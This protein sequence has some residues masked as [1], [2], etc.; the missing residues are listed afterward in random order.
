MIQASFSCLKGLG[1]SVE[2]RLWQLGC[3]SWDQFA[4]LPPK[5]LSP[6]KEQQVWEEIRQ[7][8]YALDA[9]WADYFIHRFPKADKIRVLKEF[10]HKTAYVDIETTGLGRKDTITTIAVLTHD[11][12]RI[13][14]KGFNRKELP[15]LLK[16]TKLLVT[17]NGTR[18]DLPFLRRHFNIDLTIPHLDL[19]PILSHMGYKGGQKRCEDAM[20]IRRVHS[21]GLDGAHAPQLWDQWQH[22]KDTNALKELIRYNAEDALMLEQLA[23]RAYNK[24]MAHFPVGIRLKSSHQKWPMDAVENFCNAL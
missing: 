17:F 24:A 8:Q 15:C 22:H 5:T 13:L 4:F 14:V 19:Y 11:Q 7:A 9:Q 1:T 10:Q 21:R 6:A 18:F 16:D 3:L 2:A 23:V 12:L 20:G